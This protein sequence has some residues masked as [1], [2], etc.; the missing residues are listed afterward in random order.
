MLLLVY[1]Y[2]GF[3]AA[4]FATGEVRNPRKDAPFALLTALTSVAVLYT[5]I[6]FVVIHTL[7][8]AAATRTPIADSARQF[9]GAK[10][11]ALIGMGIVVSL[12]GY[13]SANMLHTPRLTFAL[14]ERGDFPSAFAAIHKKF[15]TPYFSIL[16]FAVIALAFSV[17]GDFPWGARLSAVA[18][19]FTYGA[20]ALALPVMRRK[21][22]EADAFRLP[23][24][25]LFTVLALGFTGVLVARMNVGEVIVVGITFVL[26]FLNWVWARKRKQSE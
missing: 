13:V 3:E 24:G 21:R 8:G 5:T 7:A 16:V 10:G 14:G 12:Y 4:L 9:L 26:A 25:L 15:R 2:G 17:W 6:Q 20:V 11:G 18:R 19:L 1:S 22:P 23:A